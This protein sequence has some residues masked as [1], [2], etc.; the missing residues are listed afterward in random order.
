M[1]PQ[2]LTVGLLL[3]QTIAQTSWGMKKNLNL[4]MDIEESSGQMNFKHVRLRTRIIAI[5]LFILSVNTKVT[6]PLTPTGVG[7]MPKV[8]PS[9]A[10]LGICGIRS[11]VQTLRLVRRT[12]SW[13]WNPIFIFKTSLPCRE[14][15][16]Y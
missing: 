8:R 11:F 6:L 14:V 2:W 10:T 7:Y 9:T 16:Y 1:F 12:V 3:A 5:S 15:F 4:K 13:V